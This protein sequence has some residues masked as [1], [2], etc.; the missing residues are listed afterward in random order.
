SSIRSELNGEN[1]IL[2]IHPSAN[3]HVSF[4]EIV[5]SPYVKTIEVPC[6]YED[7]IRMVPFPN[8]STCRH[9]ASSYVPKIFMVVHFYHVGIYLGNGEVCHIAGGKDD[10]RGIRN[11]TG[12]NCEHA[13]NMIAYGIEW[14]KQVAEKPN[15]AEF[16]GRKYAANKSK[17]GLF[18]LKDEI[19]RANSRLGEL[20]NQKAKEIK[21]KYEARIETEKSRYLQEIPTKQECMSV[22]DEV[23]DQHLKELQILEKEYNFILPNSPTQKAGH[24][25]SPKFHPVVRQNPMLSLDSVDSYEG[26]LKFDERVKKLL[27]TDQ[28]IEYVCE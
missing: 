2:A 9:A 17:S 6:E 25:A 23:Y 1:P 12:Q 4:S 21:D 13:T 18:I 15:L 24:P 11:C 16:A 19:K 22:K 20:D 5:K 3:S 10:G 7:K 14:S 8:R 28:E 26:L 27:K